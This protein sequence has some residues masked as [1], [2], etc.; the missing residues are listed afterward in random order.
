MNTKFMAACIF[1][2]I[3]AGCGDSNENESSKI[4]EQKSEIHT[5]A[6]SKQITNESTPKPES[7][8]VST[9]PSPSEQKE[10]TPQLSQNTLDKNIINQMGKLYIQ[11]CAMC[12]GDYAEKAA[13]GK[14]EIISKFSEQQI[15]DALHGYKRGTFGGDYKANMIA[16]L[17]TLN[18]EQI[19]NLAA[20]I[21]SMKY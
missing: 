7:S 15:K 1:A 21:S 13:L 3:L 17:R 4:Q 20:Y 9:N 14:S 6:S 19:D 10:P 16:V 5:P 8:Q 2:A 11:K 12:H 18:D